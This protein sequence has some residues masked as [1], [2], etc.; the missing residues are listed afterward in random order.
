V[1]SLTLGNPMQG[2]SSSFL[3]ETVL[4]IRAE[5]EHDRQF[6]IEIQVNSN[7]C[8]IN[9]SLFYWAQLYGNQLDRGLA[10]GR[11]RPVICVNI[12]TFTLFADLPGR[13]NWFMIRHATNPDYLLTEDLVMHY[14]ELYKPGTAAGGPGGVELPAEP[15]GCSMHPAAPTRLQA[16]MEL[17]RRE[18][19]GEDM[20]VLLNNDLI[21]QKAHEAFQ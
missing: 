11:L 19:E 4:D 1:R 13:H 2:R 7:P 17:L 14:I 5:D 20:K 16:W 9:R 3:K 21:F 8:F 6:D 18:R 15:A 10:Y 12:L